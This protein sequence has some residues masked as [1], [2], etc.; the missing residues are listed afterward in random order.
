[1]AGARKPRVVIVGSINAD[2]GVRV[3]RRPLPGET[4]FGREMTL[5]PGGKGANQ[6]VAAARLGASTAM[7]GAVGSDAYSDVALSG[8]L[9]A[10]VCLDAV[11]RL[12]AE[13]GI[14]TGIAMVTVGPDGE[15]SIIVVPG[16]NGN[17]DSHVVAAHRGL[18]ESAAVVVVQ[19][20]IPRDGIEAAAELVCGRLIVNLA[21]VVEVSRAVLLAANP[22]VV[23]EH[24]AAAVVEMLGEAGSAALDA[25]S[26]GTAPTGTEPK[27]AEPKDAEAA[28]VQTL[29][30]QGIR[31][32]VL[33]LGFR[34]A[35]V[36]MRD[37]VDF[38]PAHGAS[39]TRSHQVIAIPSPHV[40]AIDTTG[41]GDAFVGALAY[42]LAHGDDLLTAS[43]FAVRVG[44]YSVQGRGAQSSYPDAAS[45]LPEPRPA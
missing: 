22:L 17:V 27:G 4:L 31:S 24:E 35:M 3:D 1:M 39:E 7:I 5:S 43:S 15:N 23:N 38:V 33:T 32:V 16:A 40:A 21:P 11:E 8:L 14:G 26:A 20:E 45:D 41:A 44:A 12:P 42:A 29:L 2:I 10:G 9:G 37:A 28:T 34:G 36:G 19:G 13:S 6:A 18:I 25:E 30:A